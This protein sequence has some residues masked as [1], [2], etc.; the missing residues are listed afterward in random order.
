MSTSPLAEEMDRIEGRRDRPRRPSRNR[1]GP[2]GFS[3]VR[4][5]VFPGR[6]HRRFCGCSHRDP[7]TTPDAFI[8][9]VH[10]SG[11]TGADAEPTCCGRGYRDSLC[12]EMDLAVRRHGRSWAGTAVPVFA[13]TKRGKQLILNKIARSDRPVLV[14]R[15]KLPVYG[16][17]LPE[18]LL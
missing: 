8:F 18:P 10:I 12:L 14:S 4:E 5:G 15:S 17:E 7:S 9:G 1:P 13:L 3:R 2:R 6:G 16:T 11:I